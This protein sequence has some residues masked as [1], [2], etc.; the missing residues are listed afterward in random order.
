MKVNLN[1]TEEYIEEC[2]AYACSLPEEGMDDHTMQLAADVFR[3]AK[4][5][6]AQHERLV[7]IKERLEMLEDCEE[8]K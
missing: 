7:Y 8:D 1:N 3:L 2:S 5:A 4:L 6:Q